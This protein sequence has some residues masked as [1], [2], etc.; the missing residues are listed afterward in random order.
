M[1]PCTPSLGEHG[2][3][4]RDLCAWSG[5]FELQH[6]EN[7]VVLSSHLLSWLWV[8]PCHVLSLV[9]SVLS[10]VGE[11]SGVVETVPAF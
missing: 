7:R 9:P 11:P 5:T 6:P 1:I 8:A 2:V 4:E 3:R 10:S